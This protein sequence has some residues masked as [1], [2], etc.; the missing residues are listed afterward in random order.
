MNWLKYC[1]GDNLMITCLQKDNTFFKTESTH[2]LFCS[3]R[4][5]LK[6]NIS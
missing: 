1:C 3:G 4:E 5:M 6:Q 2:S